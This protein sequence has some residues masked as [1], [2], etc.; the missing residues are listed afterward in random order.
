MKSAKLTHGGFYGHFASR[1]ELISEALKWALKDDQAPHVSANGS[2]GV[3]S[4]GSFLNDY[5]SKA[6]R[7]DRIS[8][9]GISALAADVVRTSPRL[10]RIM[11]GHI[12]K[13][14]DGI[15]KLVDDE[16][17]ADFVLLAVSAIVGAITL[18]RAMSGEEMSDRLLLTTRKMLLELAEGHPQS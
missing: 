10:R 4:F 16:D 13:F 14:I 17:A 3:R 15:S 6:H 5:L 1:D 8:G 9:C 2:K 12:A 7:D 11:T 18:S